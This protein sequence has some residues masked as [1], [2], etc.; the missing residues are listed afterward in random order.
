MAPEDTWK[1]E[2]ERLNLKIDRLS[3]TNE[4]L[5]LQGIRQS[6]Q[7]SE[8][9]DQ[10][11]T[12]SQ[13]I[14]KLSRTIDELRQ[15][16]AAKDARIAQLEE[17]KNKNSGNSSKPSSTDFFNKPKPSSI[18]KGGKAS[19]KKRTGGQKGHRGSTLE[20]KEE[21][22]VIHRCLPHQCTLCKLAE[23]CRASF[24][25]VDVRIVSQ[26]TRHDRLHG[27]CP[28]SGLPVTGDYPQGVNA[29]LQYGSNL[30]A[31]V[32]ALSSF[33]MV[34]VSRIREL[35]DGICGVSVSEG[36]VCN[37]LCDC[38]DRCNS[39]VPE[40]KNL[41]MASDTAHFDE[42]GIRVK[43]KV[44]WAH[45]ASTEQVTL[46]SSH[47][48]RG[49]EGILA[50]G[51]LKGFEGVAVH[52]CWGSYYHEQFSSV[53]HAVCGAHIDRELEGVIQNKKQRW[54]RSMQNL[55]GTLYKTK[56][57]LMENGIGCAPKEML[58]D[59]SRQYD[60]ILE[61]AFSRNPF[62]A[63]KVKKRG[64]PK[65]EK[66]RILIERLRE[67]KDDVLR[68]FTD[69]RVPFSNNIGEKS[70]RMSKLK[71]KVAG[72]FR[73]ADGGSNFCTIFSIIDTVRKNGGNAFKALVQ[74]FN[75]SFS[76][77]FLG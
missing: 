4:K 18:N 25:V 10:N 32:V 6:S 55:L 70:F 59:F 21:P 37:I 44:H 45:T 69:F 8:V 30:K 34:S 48:K 31:M 28:R 40:L 17:Q 24:D 52:D 60:R 61:R 56:K 19:P 47:H 15:V 75:N 12:Q 65:K 38:A 13:I 71:M 2:F 7:L 68:F 20:L 46:I 16:I 5:V 72:S 33:G 29:P 23:T 50:G 51:I 41:V 27:L 39:L 14:E 66:V 73:S 35:M 63:P 11:R 43:G 57:E 58:E 76:L 74:L 53:T 49:V 67:L 26:Q 9:N 62:Q 64:R 77:A 1:K 42:T 3:A 54:A 22:D 36:T